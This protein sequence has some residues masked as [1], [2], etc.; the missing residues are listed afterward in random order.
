MLNLEHSMLHVPAQS[1][2]NSPNK[3][4]NDSAHDGILYTQ[5]Q[6]LTTLSDNLTT[7][8]K[9]YTPIIPTSC[10]FHVVDKLY[11]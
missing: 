3:N 8:Y 1:D 6:L 9:N 10:K 4:P 11:N 5:L 2:N 7:Y